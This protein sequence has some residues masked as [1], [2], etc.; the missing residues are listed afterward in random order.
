M[1]GQ[2]TDVTDSLLLEE[3]GASDEFESPQKSYF[4]VDAYRLMPSFQFLQSTGSWF[5]TQEEAGRVL[6]GMCVNWA[7]NNPHGR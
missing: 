5:A 1:R 4:Y 6:T 2:A 3:L 7:N